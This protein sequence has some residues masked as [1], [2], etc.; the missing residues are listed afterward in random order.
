[1]YLEE[2]RTGKE[3][4]AL[5]SMRKYPPTT[6]ATSIL[7]SL[8]PTSKTASADD[9]SI[10]DRRENNQPL[11]SRNADYNAIADRITNGVKNNHFCA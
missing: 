10:V 1:L 11:Y 7:K 8:R 6:N 4:L 3:K 2:I 9:I 5:Q